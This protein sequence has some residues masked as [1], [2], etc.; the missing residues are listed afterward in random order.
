MMPRWLDAGRVRGVELD[1]RGAR[2]LHHGITQ[3][4]LLRVLAF[5][6]RLGD[7]PTWVALLLLVPLLDARDG[8]EVARLMGVLG[9]I[10]L[11]LYYALKRTTRRQRPFEQCQDIR[12]ALPP[13]D[14]YSF[15]SGHTLHAVGFGVLLAWFYPVLAP[16][17]GLFAV[18][19]GLSRIALG[20]HYPSDVLIGAAVGAGS[21]AAV[22]VIFG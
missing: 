18:L 7:A 20:L 10:N 14:A 22:L 13:P 16:L 2:A 19:V 9:A 11:A 17:L 6:S 1:R 5:A 3:P 21:A 15:P 12:A 8:A 4:L